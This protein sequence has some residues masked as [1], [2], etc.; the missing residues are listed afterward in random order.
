MD[1]TIYQLEKLRCNLCGE[2]FTAQPPKEVGAKKY[3]ERAGSMVALLKYGSGFPF[4]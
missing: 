3:D 4:H 1:A 2:I